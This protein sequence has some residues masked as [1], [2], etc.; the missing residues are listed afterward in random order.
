MQNWTSFGTFVP[1]KSNPN[2]SGLDPSPGGD[3][4]QTRDDLEDMNSLEA[5][6]N[7]YFVDITENSDLFPS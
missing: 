1:Q 6:L 2:G 4:P 7:S 3:L 5:D